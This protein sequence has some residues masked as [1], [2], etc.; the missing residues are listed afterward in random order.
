MELAQHCVNGAVLQCGLTPGGSPDR[1]TVSVHCAVGPIFRIPVSC[2]PVQIFLPGQQQSQAINQTR[3]ALSKQLPYIRE[4]GLIAATAYGELVLSAT[5]S[6]AVSK[7]IECT[8][9]KRLAKL[10][11]GA[12]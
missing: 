8:L 7:A 5:E 12:A 2:K 3:Y 9:N 10:E 1:R 11:G 4:Q 6:K